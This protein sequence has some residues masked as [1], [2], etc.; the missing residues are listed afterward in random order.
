MSD[1]LDIDVR[2]L[3][4]GL[5]V[6]LDMRWMTHPFPLNSFRLASA[7]QIETLRAMG[8]SSVRILPARS[9]PAALQALVEAG[10]IEADAAYKKERDAT[11][12]AERATDVRKAKDKQEAKE[13]KSKSKRPTLY[14]KG[15]KPS[16]PKP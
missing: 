15:E 10:V 5:H 14:K 4:V 13:E 11:M 3:R 2:H 7:E 12:T 8:L 9:L 6:Q 16:E 1:T